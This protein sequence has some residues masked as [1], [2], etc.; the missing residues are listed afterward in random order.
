MV[1]TERVR[2]EFSSLIEEEVSEED[3][4]VRMKCALDG[5]ST[6]EEE[7]EEQEISMLDTRLV[8]E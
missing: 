6:E 1:D 5:T 4:L 3:G 2:T 7:E 8:V